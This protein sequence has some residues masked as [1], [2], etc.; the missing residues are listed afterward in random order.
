MSSEAGGSTGDRG[1]TAAAWRLAVDDNGRG[2]DFYGRFSLDELDQAR[3]GPL[4]IKQ[5]VRGMGGTLALAS[6][7]GHGSRLE[8]TVP[9]KTR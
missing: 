8:V 4:V 1:A 2:F 9:R 5:R 6:T 3:R 7:R